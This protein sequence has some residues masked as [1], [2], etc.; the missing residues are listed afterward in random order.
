MDRVETIFS[1]TMQEIKDS[2]NK[3]N[4]ILGDSEALNQYFEQGYCFLYDFPKYA[5]DSEYIHAYPGIHGDFLIFMF[6]PSKFD[7]AETKDIQNYVKASHAM[8]G[9]NGGRI[10]KE[11]AMSRISDWVN[12][13]KTWVKEQVDRPE[14]MFRAFQIDRED[15]ELANTENY[16]GLKRHLL[17]HKTADLIVANLDGKD[18]AQYFDDFSKPVPP[19]GPD[20]PQSSFYLLTL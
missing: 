5:E 13:H 18:E 20:A 1:L 16:L 6:I 15:Y 17:S 8:Q 4:D 10:T 19:F 12:H 14:G 11:E 2:I 3:W 9:Q 7:K